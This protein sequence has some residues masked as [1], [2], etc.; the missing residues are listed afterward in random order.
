MGRPPIGARPMTN[1][2]RQ[3]RWRATRAAALVTL[4][5]SG[6]QGMRTLHVPHLH[7]TVARAQRR[8]TF[9]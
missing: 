5:Q 3:A 9:G 4:D 1:A 8:S 6:R 7:A 2:E